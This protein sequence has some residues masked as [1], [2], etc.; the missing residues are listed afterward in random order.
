MKKYKLLLKRFSLIILM[1]LLTG[2]ANSCSMF[3]VTLYGKTI[4]GNNE[5][6]WR[7]DSQIWFETGTQ[8]TYGVAYVGHND[9]FPQ[10]GMNEAGLAFDGF[11]VYPR[12]L[13]PVIG[14]KKV[15]NPADFIKM[16]LQRCKST[17]EVK[18]LMN[19]YDRSV[20]NSAMLLFV[21]KTGK[22]LVVEVDTTILGNEPNYVLSNFC[23][24]IISNPDDVQIG[25][26]QRGRKF[27]A[28]KS[29]TSLSFCISMMDTMHECRNK[30]GDGT[31]YSSIYDLNEGL[32]NLYFY[33]DYTHRV[34]FSL[35]EELKRGNHV[36]RM[37][38]IFPQNKE[39]EKFANFKT[40]FNDLRLRLLLIALSGFLLLA[41]LFYLFLCLQGLIK[42][43]K[44]FSSSK[45]NILGLSTAVL[46][47][48]L[49]FFMY[50]LL[51]N[52]SVFYFDTAYDRSTD[53][54]L[55][56]YSI[57]FPIVFLILTVPVII[58]IIRILRRNQMTQFYKGIVFLNSISYII[59][60]ILF[61]YWK[62]F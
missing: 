19:Q 52:Q 14:K 60:L 5:D 2:I 21:D 44:E 33:H 47:I 37:L 36:I 18:E 39:Y 6:A 34:Q 20:F 42:K 53:L 16:I 10:G 11:T 27:L 1:L 50:I 62:L 35:L 40:T 26:Y 49:I 9:L 28:N 31:T 29:D 48:G 32:I 55:Y 51:T 25:R 56:Y 54:F 13:K 46:N 15:E 45:N 24:S 61:G 43:N 41:V 59:I 12:K 7:L 23:P 22:Y 3:K 57:Y 4:V 58:L 8:H 17:E 38:N 30:I